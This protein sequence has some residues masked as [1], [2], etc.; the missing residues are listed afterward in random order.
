MSRGL[1]NLPA[2]AGAHREKNTEKEKSISKSIMSGWDAY[3]TA[4]EAYPDV[5]QAAIHGFPDGGLWATSAGFS[6]P[7]AKTLCD[8]LT[9][10]K[11]FAGQKVQAGG[12][13]YMAL[14]CNNDQLMGKSGPNSIAV[15]KSGKALIVCLGT[16]GMNAGTTLDVAFK[17]AADLTSK[18]F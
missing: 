1:S 2:I 9:N 12:V 18:G 17:M 4:L 10:P 13:G 15:V 7:E 14:L 6:V 16:E 11:N 8:R 5:H 3:I